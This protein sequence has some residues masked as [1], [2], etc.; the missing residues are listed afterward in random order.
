M[1]VIDVLEELAKSVQQITFRDNNVDREA[2]I[3]FAL[4]VVEL[5][6]DP[7][8]SFLDSFG[9]IFDQTVGGNN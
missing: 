1:W 4:D 5:S 2:D 6:R 8:S 9:W 3:E 7:S